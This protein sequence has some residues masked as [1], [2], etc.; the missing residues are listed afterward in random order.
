MTLTR[1]IWD[2]VASQG[3]VGVTARMV[4]DALG[5]SMHCASEAITRLMKAGSIEPTGR[6]RRYDGARAMN[7]YRAI[8]SAPPPGRG[9]WRAARPQKPKRTQIECAPLVRLP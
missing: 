8:E 5:V 9:N 7:T 4:A 1:K 2:F 6:K 3:G